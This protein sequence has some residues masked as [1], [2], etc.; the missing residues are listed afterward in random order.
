MLSRGSTMSM[1]GSAKFIGVSSLESEGGLLDISGGSRDTSGVSVRLMGGSGSEVSGGSAIV[2][3]VLLL[4]L[5]FI[6][7]RACCRHFLVLPRRIFCRQRR[8]RCTTLPLPTFVVVSVAALILEVSQPETLST[9][10]LYIFILL[11]NPY[12]IQ[13]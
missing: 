6:C 8:C 7:C 2:S 9:L 5:I 11:I 1:G 3:S 10:S 13:F 4:L 12:G